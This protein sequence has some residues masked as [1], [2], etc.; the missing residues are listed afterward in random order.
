MFSKM[1]YKF[2]VL[3][4]LF[5]GVSQFAFSQGE[6]TVE[7]LNSNEMEF[8]KRDEGDLKKL[9]GNVILKQADVM[10]YCDSAYFN[11]GNNS[12]EAF[13]NVKVKQGDSITLYCR[14]L[15]YNG[16]EKLMHA[17]QKVR[18]E[19]GK[20]T[21]LSDNIDYDLRQKKGWYINGGKLLNDSTLL[22]SKLGNYY[23]ESGNAFFKEKV[24]VTN[25][26]YSLTADTFQYNVKSN[27][28]YFLGATNITTDSTKVY[29]EGGYYNLN[30]GESRFLTNAHINTNHQDVKA[31]TI[32]FNQKTKVGAAFGNVWFYDTLQKVL[33]HSGEAHFN[34]TTNYLKTFRNP[35]LNTILDNDTLK[36]K[37]DT[38]VTQSITIIS[39]D[40]ALTKKDTTERKILLAYYHVKMYSKKFQAVCDSSRYSFVDSSFVL[41]HQPVLWVD[42]NQLSSDTIQI[43]TQQNKIHH[44]VLMQNAMIVSRI[45]RKLYNQVGGRWIEGYFINN[46]LNDMYV[47]GNAESV[48]FSV[49]KNN[50]YTGVNKSSSSRMHFKFATGKMDKIFFYDQPEAY[51][52]PMKFYKIGSMNLKNFSWK[53]DKKP[54]R[55]WFR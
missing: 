24:K 39:N 26:H 18:L 51:F 47:N 55:S 16:N 9:T 45:H 10:M 7:I 17:N 32:D 34:S 44:L 1:I 43:F 46:E 38:L 2:L 48:Y 11:D 50:A 29:C 3:T 31:D 27:T 25:P 15:L 49:D 5:F 30:S 36:I 33:I 42:S 13:G 21:L 53:S 14:H 40:S 6:K 19:R 54:V 4:I 37:A 41:Y 22:I 12:V 23:A 20:S 35:Q 52:T 28:N 8:M